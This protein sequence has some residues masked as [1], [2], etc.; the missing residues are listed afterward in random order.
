MTIWNYTPK[1]I[2]FGFAELTR[3]R[4]SVQAIYNVLCTVAYSHIL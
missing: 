2:D 1:L 4:G 3:K